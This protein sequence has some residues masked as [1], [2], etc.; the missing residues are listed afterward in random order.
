M[1]YELLEK[2]I[3]LLIQTRKAC[4]YIFDLGLQ[5]ERLCHYSASLRC[6]AVLYLIRYILKQKSICSR[7]KKGGRKGSQYSNIPLWSEALEKFTSHHDTVILRRVSGVYLDALML[8]QQY[9]VQF[10]RRCHLGSPNSVCWMIWW[11]ESELNR[12]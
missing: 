8:T 7:S 3:L 2:T 12:C 10:Y 4:N 6:A 9:G 1:T 5:D 11:S